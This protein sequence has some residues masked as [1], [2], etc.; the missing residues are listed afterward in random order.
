MIRIS[1]TNPYLHP[2]MNKNLRVSFFVL[3]LIQVWQVANAQLSVLPN[4]N[5]PAINLQTIPS[6]AYEAGKLNIKFLPKYA[7]AIPNFSV[8]HGII[9][10]T[11]NELNKALQLLSCH[12]VVS[13]F[14]NV[15]PN[16]E[17][18]DQHHQFGL[19]RWFTIGFDN[20][21][22]IP[23]AIG[24][25][26]KT[27]L[28]EVVEPVFK[29]QLLDDNTTSVNF[30]PNDP[31]FNKQWSFNNTGQ[32][33]GLVGAD[34]KLTQAWDIETGN[35]S[36]L[37]SVHD[38]GIQPNHPDLAQNLNLAKSFNF[39]DNNASIVQGNHGTHVA[40][41]IAAVNNN[42]VGVSGIAGGNGNPNSGIRMLSMQVYKGNSS[43]GH[44]E[45]FVLAANNGVCISNNSWAYIEP[46]VY[47]LVVMDAIDY[48]IA[49]G[50]GTTLQ[51]GL[52]IFA[53]GNISRPAQL[54]PSAYDK[55]ICVA[56]TNNKDEKSSYSTF[57]S[58]VDIAAPGGAY[59]GETSILS[60]SAFD[61][62]RYDHGTSMAAP[63]VTGV[64]A[65]VA[66]VLAGKCS[67]ADV[68]EILLTSVDDISA[69]N[70]AFKNTLGVGRL[71]AFKAVQKA[72]QLKNGLVINT[73]QTFAATTTCNN[74][75][76]NWQ[77]N[78]NN[79]DVI[80]LYSNENNIPFLTNGSNYNVGNAVGNAIVIYKG[81]A[82]N[83]TLPNNKNAFHYFKLFSVNNNQYSFSKSIA[84]TNT[85]FINNSG[86]LVEA[87]NYPPYFPTQD[88]RS[89]DP[90]N[91][92]SWM[93]SAADTSSTGYNDDYSMAM[94][95]YQ[96]N[97]FE[98]RV[99]WLQSPIYNIAN[100]D[101]IKLSF[102]HAYQNRSVNPLLSDS[103]EVLV[104]NNCG[105]NFTTL[106]RQGG[107]AL[108]TVPGSPNA[109]FKPFGTDKWRAHTYNLTH[110]KNGTGLQLQ[111]KAVNGKGNNI[112]VDNVMVEINYKTDLALSLVNKDIVPKGCNTL[113]E[114][115][116]NFT[117]KGNNTITTA[118]IR[119]TI[120]NG[121]PITT[122]WNGNLLK[123]NAV[124]LALN[125][126]NATV[127]KHVLK[128]YSHLPNNVADDFMLNDTITIP[129]EILPTN[130]SLPLNE[131]FEGTV[132]PPT[133]WSIVQQPLDTLT[134][135][136]ATNAS[137]FGGNK[138]AVINNFFYNYSDKRK[139]DLLS[140]IY[141]ITQTID[142]AFLMYSYAHATKA[143]PT[144]NSNF[145]TLEVAFT[146]DCGT[147][148]QVMQKRWGSNLQTINQTAAETRFFSP[149]INNW[150]TDSFNLTGRFNKGDKVQLRFRNTQN[151]GNNL[152]IDAI[153]LYTKTIPESLKQNGYIVYPNP[154]NQKI[155]VEH[156]QYPSNLQSIRLVNSLGKVVLVTNFSNNLQPIQINTSNLAT[157]MYA[158]Q[159]IYPNAIVTQ[160]LIKVQ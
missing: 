129:F 69:I 160:K 118:S 104:S 110:L 148:W 51:G 37:V 24:Y 38:Q 107:A 53:A 119:Y 42:G 103:L 8:Q 151:F 94:Y 58:W 88:W 89:I 140:P 147:T 70:P 155:V 16:I 18:K 66:S 29:K 20:S 40:G 159:L 137:T 86:Q 87:F 50:G 32:A 36:V 77:K 144:S 141:E 3:M 49:N 114:P 26:Q 28:F 123:N 35:P 55:V 143:T 9:T 6:T 33:N 100:V 74:I 62:Y 134:W 61:G 27:N 46:N 132:F 97:P 68:R 82:S 21:I 138:S 142:S 60:T 154:F 45:S 96:Y 19:Q 121:S 153:K 81:N 22:S 2:L 135:A 127:G 120:D 79:N 39:I 43:G 92:F 25:L 75:N 52:V 99:D 17:F 4:R 57:G 91:D 136:N 76:L 116:V 10:S 105:A 95:N 41:T 90:D 15:L 65:L 7:N 146:K 84:I 1:S 14:K 150:G 80:V 67:A 126:S 108:A 64:A 117:N 145:D 139:D 72:Q 78:T 106:F 30:T 71:N 101:S 34:I 113:I 122:N 54:F 13:P 158:V 47:E 133:N 98:G 5:L 149:T 56:A 63:H 111:F 102:Y 130:N 23:L 73:P 83:F 128:L 93:H 112:Y 85:T 31:D 125:T 115:Q 131:S 12:N 157:G 11:H 152:Y 156:L 124:A 109:E 48:F 44:A 59:G